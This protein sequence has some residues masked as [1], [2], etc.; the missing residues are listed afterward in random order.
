MNTVFLFREEHKNKYK[1]YIRKIKYN[2]FIIY[3][4]SVF[5]FVGYKKFL[6]LQ[7]CTLGGRK[8]KSRYLSEIL[9][10]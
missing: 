10:A 6:E 9:Y 1:L 4:L 7:N 5:N 2:S 8:C 3:L